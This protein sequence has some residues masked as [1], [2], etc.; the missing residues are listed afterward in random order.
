MLQA[1]SEKTTLLWLLAACFRKSY[2]NQ[3]VIEQQKMKDASS[4][5]TLKRSKRVLNETFNSKSDCLFCGT[6]VVLEQR[7]YSYVKTHNSTSTFMS[8]CWK[9]KNEWA[10]IVKSRIEY[11]GTDLYAANSIY[12]HSCRNNFRNGCDIPIHVQEKSVTDA[13]RKK[14]GRPK[15]DDKDQAFERMCKYLEINC[16]EQLTVTFLEE[17]MKGF[18]LHED[19]DPYGN[20]YLKIKLK[21][22]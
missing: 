18:I 19:S 8:Y 10:S 9:R 12:Y 2:I 5:N 17:K 3:R 20:Q 15:D 4:S 1:L 7:D 22:K 13:K 16:E 21:E 14:S 11:Y 6:H